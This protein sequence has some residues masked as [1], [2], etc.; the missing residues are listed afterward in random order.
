MGCKNPLAVGLI[1]GV[2]HFLSVWYLLSGVLD[3]PSAIGATV[4]GYAGGITVLLIGVVVTLCNPKDGEDE[5][6]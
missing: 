4:G 6:P 1:L 3:V 5:E 2:A